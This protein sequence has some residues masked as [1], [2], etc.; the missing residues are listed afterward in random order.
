VVTACFRPDAFRLAALISDRARVVA[1]AFTLILILILAGCAPVSSFDRTAR[2]PAEPASPAA[3]HPHPLGSW[4]TRELA[5]NQDSAVALV[6]DEKVVAVLRTGP[7]KSMVAA[8]DRVNAAVG[9]TAAGA[10]PELRLIEGRAA[11]AFAVASDRQPTIAFN[12]GMIS[13]IGDD[14]AMWAVVY[15]HELAHLNRRHQQQRRERSALGETASGFL[16]VVLSFAGLP[17]APLFTD[18][19]TALVN[20]GYSREDELEADALAVSYLRQAGYDSAAALRFHERL[21]QRSGDTG[22]LLSTHPGG[23]ERVE[24][25]RRQVGSETPR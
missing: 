2:Q 3:S 24:A 11:N 1:P 23:L 5:A 18:G 16:S 21:A 20:L 6:R 9:Q 19:A 7:L 25:I 13:L 8:A 4:A 14:E 22:G 12:F 10:T 15:G 17:F